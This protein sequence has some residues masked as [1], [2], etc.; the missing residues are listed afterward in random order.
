VEV[1]AGQAEAVSALF[2]AAGLAV[3]APRPDMDGRA[4]VVLARRA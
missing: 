2:R 3:E 1:G 4:R